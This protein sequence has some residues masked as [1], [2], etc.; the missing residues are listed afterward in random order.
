MNFVKKASD[1][2]KLVNLDS[3]GL[4]VGVTFYLR[5]D[6]QSL[7]ENGIHQNVLFLLE[8]LK[9]IPYIRKTFIISMGPGDRK[10]CKELTSI[11][12][13]QFVNISE[14]TSELD[15]VIELGAQL[16][17]DWAADFR[18]KGGKII[19]MK[20][21]NDFIIDAERMVFDK[22][23]G[24]LFSTIKYDQI[25]TIKSFEKTCAQYYKHGFNAPVV[26]MPHIW[27]PHLIEK[28]AKRDKRMFRYAPGRKRWRLAILEPNI[29]SVKTCHV[30]LVVSDVAHRNNS[31]FIEHVSVFNSLALKEHA[32]FVT[33]ARSLDIVNQGIATF[34]GRFPTYQIMTEF[35]DAIV[36]YQWENA[37]NYLYY[38]ALYGGYPLIHN[39]S[40]IADCGYRYEECDV[41]DGSLALL[42]AYHSHDKNIVSYRQKA[43]TFLATL[44]PNNSD[45]VRHF[46][47]AIKSLF[48][49]GGA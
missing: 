42:E 3:N 31:K 24:M 19:G 39:S 1:L 47:E 34:E 8:L 7:W 16:S 48:N 23:A 27:S 28:A 22:P 30:P 14:I 21:A 33:F 36:S 9:N 17:L 13:Y 41:N 35:S 26:V 29:C 18:S 5:G 4:N 49:G 2:A 12:S 11:S 38:E 40:L 25:W 6:E 32:S 37:Q 15:V 43:K 46:S 10:S 44:L 45:N 20:V